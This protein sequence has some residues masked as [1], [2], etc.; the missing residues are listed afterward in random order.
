MST[1]RSTTTTP[2]ETGTTRAARTTR[3]A[4]P[5]ISTPKRTPVSTPRERETLVVQE[6]SVKE[7]FSEIKLEGVPLLNEYQIDQLL[8]LTLGPIDELF[9]SN[10]L[11]FFYEVIGMIVKNG[12]DKTL[13][14]LKSKPWVSR[15]QIILMNPNL[16]N[17]RLKIIRDAEIF[18]N[19]KLVMS[20][21]FKCKRC[22]SENTSYVQKQTRSA[23]EGMTTFITCED[24]NNHW[25]QG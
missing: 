17:A 15:D 9:R 1:P 7:L 20:G 2:R 24:C 16:E 5:K 23:D 18:R 8:G 19:K 3:T 12:F 6:K 13:E 10:D 4:R 25:V 14:Y 11:Y 21:V 22:G